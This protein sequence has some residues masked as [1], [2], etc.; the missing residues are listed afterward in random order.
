[1][2]LRCSL[3]SSLA[4]LF[5]IMAE[6]K[7]YA[8]PA[9]GPAYPTPAYPVPAYPV[10]TQP[11][12][13]QPVVC[14]HPAFYIMDRGNSSYLHVSQAVVP[15]QVAGNR[16]AKNR[17]IRSN[18]KRGWSYGLCSFFGSCGTCTQL[19]PLRVLPTFD[20]FPLS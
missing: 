13:T 4:A 6:P 9:P 12:Y 2:R 15:M 19:L 10:V 3:S 20:S 14:V 11:V 1:M 17:P 5:A 18:G 8:Y 7:Q 16:N